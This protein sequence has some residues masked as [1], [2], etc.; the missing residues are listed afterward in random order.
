MDRLG[1]QAFEMKAQYTLINRKIEWLNNLNMLKYKRGRGFI[2]FA[3]E[4]R[5]STMLIC[6]ILKD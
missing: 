6:L 4:T 2:G 3:D 5:G 1:K